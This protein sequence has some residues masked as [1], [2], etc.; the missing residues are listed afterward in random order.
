MFGPGER[1]P[2]KRCFRSDRIRGC[3]V[4]GLRELRFVTA[5][6]L[7]SLLVRRLVRVRKRYYELVTTGWAYIL[8]GL[9][10]LLSTVS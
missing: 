6:P 3:R 1:P 9:I 2:V 10:N 8:S 4:C 5:A 7:A